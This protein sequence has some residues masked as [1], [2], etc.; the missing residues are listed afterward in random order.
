MA[1]TIRPESSLVNCGMVSTASEKASGKMLAN[2]SP[3]T[4]K[5]LTATVRSGT[6]RPARARM[7]T[8][9]VTM[10]NLRG[11]IQVRITPPEKRPMVRAM[12]KSPVPNNPMRL[13][14]IW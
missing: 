3:T 6:N 9:E 11:E 5:L 12:K 14:S 7:E 4:K 10:K 8:N 13:M 2:P 1:V